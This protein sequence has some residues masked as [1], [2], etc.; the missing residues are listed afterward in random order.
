MFTCDVCRNEEALAQFSHEPLN[1]ENVLDKF[2][3]WHVG[4]KCTDELLIILNDKPKPPWFG[5]E[6]GSYSKSIR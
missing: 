4:P 5:E 6:R 2:Q 1:N 3:T